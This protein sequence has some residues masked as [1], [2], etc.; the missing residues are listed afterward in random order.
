MMPD[1][2]P[3]GPPHRT[4]KE[5]VILADPD[6]Q[7]RAAAAEALRADGYAVAEAATGLEAEA[8][9]WAE[10]NTELLIAAAALPGVG[11]RRLGAI[12]RVLNPG[13][14][15]L[16][17]PPQSVDELLAAVKDVLGSR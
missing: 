14:K 6:A 7:A 15:V 13:L 2:R 8:A 10:P 11:G 9:F 3:P 17:V 1:E 5:R 12:L 4:R 16:V